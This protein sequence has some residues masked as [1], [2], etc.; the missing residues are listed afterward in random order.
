[1]SYKFDTVAFA[2]FKVWLQNYLNKHVDTSLHYL[3]I[4]ELYI[5]VLKRLL[6]TEITTRKYIT[7]NFR[8]VDIAALR[9]ILVTYPLPL[10]LAELDFF[11]TK[12]QEG[13]KKIPG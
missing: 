8:S 11:L 3:V 4:Y 7:Y 2:T 13:V 9:I 5:K 12:H 1:M 10:W 6:S